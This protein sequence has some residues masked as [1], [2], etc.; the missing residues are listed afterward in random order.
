MNYRLSPPGLK[1]FEKARRRLQRL[2]AWPKPPSNSDVV[3]YL[4]RG[5]AATIRAI[6][7]PT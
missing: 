1:A 3:E 4:S 5:E 7:L 2:A 6:N